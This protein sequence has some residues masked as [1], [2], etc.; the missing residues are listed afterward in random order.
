MVL[1]S[2]YQYSG[3]QFESGATKLIN[4]SAGHENCRFNLNVD[5]KMSATK[6]TVVPMA[7]GIVTVYTVQ[8]KTKVQTKLYIYIR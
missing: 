3:K 2:R 5:K 7:M 1:K 6:V 4:A 8:H